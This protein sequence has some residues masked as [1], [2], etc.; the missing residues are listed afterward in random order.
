[1]PMDHQTS[2]DPRPSVGVRLAALLPVVWVP[3]RS[4]TNPIELRYF[5]ST[6]YKELATNK[7]NTA[8]HNYINGLRIFLASF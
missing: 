2:G 1:M 5:I 7:P 3:T 4:Q 6:N 8:I